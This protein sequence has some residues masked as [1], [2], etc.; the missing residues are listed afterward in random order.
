VLNRRQL[1]SGLGLGALVVG[2]DPT[3]RA[4][5]TAETAAPGFDRIPPLDGTLHLDEPTRRANSVDN[6]RHVTRVPAAVLR[7]GSVRDIARM[8]RF[9]RTHRIPV[10]TRGRAHSTH[11]QGLVSGLLIDSRTLATIHSIGPDTAVVDGGATWLDLTRAAVA[12]GLTPP[13]L[14]GYIGLS[15]GGTLSMGGI[16]SDSSAG[17]QVDRVR[18]LQVV[19]G[20]G[21]VVECSPSRDRAL[22]ESVLAGLG[23]YGVITRA[24]VELVPAPAMIRNYVIRY[25]DNATF[26]ADLRTLLARGELQDV[27]GQWLPGED[28]LVHH[29]FAAQPFDPARPPDDDRLLRGLSVPRSAVSSTDH[30]FLDFAE[31]VDVLI[32]RLRSA[33]SWDELVKPWFDVWLPGSATERYV[34]EVIPTLTARDVGAGGFVLL[35]P[36]LRSTLTRPMARMPEP[37]GDPWVFLF[38]ILTSADRPGPD[39]AFARDMVRRNG[40]LF[41]AARAVGGVRYPIGSIDFTRADWAAH[42]GPLW[43]QV[44]RRKRRFDPDMIMTPGLGIFG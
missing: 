34:G 26:F 10:A 35:F 44:L 17:L 38:D 2:F 30:G 29:L 14:T 31:R 9:C 21:R 11:G 7:P 33:I 27:W 1:L 43:P 13:V 36:L 37:D 28:G 39:P 25:P 32:D 41:E 23:Q 4:W 19:T 24:T 20:E 6:G 40:R 5:A 16:S 12:R 8:I 18:E 42:Y 15:I 3:G 22:F